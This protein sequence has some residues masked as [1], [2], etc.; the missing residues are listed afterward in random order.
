[1]YVTI[2]AGIVSRE[3]QAV[4]GDIERFFSA[5]RVGHYIYYEKKNK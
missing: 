5:D 1:M 3:Q 4:S 2:D